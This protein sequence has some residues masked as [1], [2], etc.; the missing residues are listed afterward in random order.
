M[1]LIGNFTKYENMKVNS[2]TFLSYDGVQTTD[3][4]YW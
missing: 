3:Q 1:R 4:L 2:T